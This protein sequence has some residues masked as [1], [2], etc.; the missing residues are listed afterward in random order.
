M[1]FRFT[2]ILTSLISGTFL[3]PASSTVIHV[4]ADAPTIQ[5][6]VNLTSPG[7]TVEVA[8]GTYDVGLGVNL[9]DEIVIRSETGFPDCVTL[10]VSGDGG[11]GLRC[12]NL[13]SGVRIEGFRLVGEEY[14]SMGIYVVNSSVTVSR[15]DIRNFCQCYYESFASGAGLRAS[16]SS[17]VT[18]ENCSFVNN[19]AESFE[20]HGYEGGAIYCRDSQLIVRSSEFVENFASDYGGAVYSSQ[21]SSMSFLDSRFERNNGW[22][23]AA[24]V[25]DALSIDRCAFI[26]NIS[27]NSGAVWGKGTIQNSHFERNRGQFGAAVHASGDAVVRNCSFRMNQAGYGAV[28]LE[29]PVLVESCL[30]EGN[31]GHRGSAIFVS[32]PGAV[33]RRCTFVGNRDSSVPGGVVVAGK[34]GF[35][36]GHCDVQNS[37]IAFSASG[38]ATGC[39]DQ[40]SITATCCDFFGNAGGDWVGCV[41]G[42]ENSNGNISADPFFCGL[43]AAKYLLQQNSPCAPPQSGDC[44][45]IGAFGVGCGP[46]SVES[47]SWGGIKGLYR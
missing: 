12:G 3:L 13:T 23:G 5:D 33:V 26:E 28:G 37:I 2:W 7:D 42:Q 6:G 9:K 35:L 18:V 36:E 44:D 31:A 8:C 41:Q 45:E 21:N 38:P 34:Y 27:T 39:F 29:G 14:F 16:N 20:G 46:V 40:G 32:Q 43:T 22:M 15:C 10:E 19:R 24:V 25:G 1:S 4:P 30:F 47:K 17:I 11:R